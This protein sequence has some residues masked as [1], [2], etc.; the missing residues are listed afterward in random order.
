MVA[1][2]EA[3]IRLY[4]GIR[5]CQQAAQLAQ[6]KRSLKVFDYTRQHR[7]RFVA[8]MDKIKEA[9][10]I[11]QKVDNEGLMHQTMHRSC[12][13]LNSRRPKSYK[14]RCLISVNVRTDK[15]LSAQSIM[16]PDQI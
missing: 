5:S 8:A 10:K 9:V 7:Q 14:K 13:M 15:D 11:L 1:E 2:Q 6:T 3:G 16:K 12:L 4:P